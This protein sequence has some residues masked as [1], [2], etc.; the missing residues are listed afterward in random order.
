MD[1]G[2]TTTAA[3]AYQAAQA[4]T[5]TPRRLHVMMYDSAIDLCRRAVQALDD[6]DVD[7]A[8]ERLARAG[9]VL[10]RLR[11]VLRTDVEPE[12]ARALSELYEQ[13]QARLVEADFYRRR[14]PLGQS[15]TLLHYRRPAWT[16]FIEA[17]CLRGACQAGPSA[18]T[19]RLA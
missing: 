14:E 17:L 13:V 3:T 2:Y 18:R 11:G 12:L 7:R 10:G 4:A 8:G 15:I 19:D 16:A 1:I 5:A 9:A 6:G